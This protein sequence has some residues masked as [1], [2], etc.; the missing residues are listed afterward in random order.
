MS[1][2]EINVGYVGQDV[3][4]LCKDIEGSYAIHIVPRQVDSGK[5]EYLTRVQSSDGIITTG[6]VQNKVSD[7]HM[8]ML[9]LAAHIEARA[10]RIADLRLKQQ[11]APVIAPTAH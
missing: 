8:I 7:R 9:A 6:L 1:D 3:I 2:L 4:A 10:K 5:V 11:V